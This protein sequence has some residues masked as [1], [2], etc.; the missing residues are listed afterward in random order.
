[1]LSVVALHRL[2]IDVRFQGGDVVGK[3]GTFVRHESASAVAVTTDGT[4]N[5]T[6]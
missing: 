4:H 6:E 2:H 3:R 5:A 1:M